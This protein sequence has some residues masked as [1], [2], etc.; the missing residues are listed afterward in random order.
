VGERH[1]S[2]LPQQSQRERAR[3]HDPTSRSQQQREQWKSVEKSVLEAHMEQ[4]QE[5]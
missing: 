3:W 2:P 5:L 1:G 4:Q